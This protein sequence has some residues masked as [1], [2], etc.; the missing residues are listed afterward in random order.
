MF[1]IRG[2]NAEHNRRKGDTRKNPNVTRLIDCPFAA[3]AYFQKK[4]NHW[5]FTVSNPTHNH[6]H[7]LDPTA[8]TENRR[9]TADLYEEMKKLGD[10]GLKPSAI[11]EALKK[12]HPNETILATISTIYSARK[13]AQHQMLQGISPIVHLNQTLEKSSFTTATKVNENGEL[14]GLFFCHALSINLLKSYHYVLLLDCTYKTNKYK[15]PLLH[16]AGITGADTTFSLAFCFLSEENE[17]YYTWALETLLKV[18]SSNNIPHPDVFL[19]D[20][21]QALINSLSNLFPNSTHLLCTW[22]IQKNLLTNASKLI[23]D[24]RKETE[25]IQHWNNLI[26]MPIQ[27]KFRAS[28]ERFSSKYGP[29]FQ[30]YM[31]STW[32]P[33]AEKYSNAWT[34][35]IPHFNHRTTSRMESA[36]AFIKSRLLGP[37]HSFTAV[38]KLIT[39]ALE[40]QSH[41]ISAQYHQ[42]KINSLKYIGEIFSE[43]H[44]R[45]THFALRKAHNN[46]L[47]SARVDKGSPCNGCHRIRTGIPCKHRIK[48]LIE[49]GEKVQPA[50]FHPQWHISVSLIFIFPYFL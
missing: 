39:N 31:H 10:A 1:L 6:E 20:Q 4:A 29:D 48:A 44:G 5:K 34:Q 11:L 22:H 16:I 41:E 46:L 49:R 27:S 3:S 7:S 37:N 26:R 24:K 8:H 15:M 13:K 9:L 47:D 38:I 30:Q 50:E 18:F 23:K 45:I 36:H 28:F 14:K 21:E 17:T 2:G 33:I 43:C 35:S 40:A 19:T 12:T 25:M 42:Q 32:L